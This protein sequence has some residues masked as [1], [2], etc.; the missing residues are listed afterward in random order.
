MEVLTNWP[1]YLNINLHGKQGLKAKKS[2]TYGILFTVGK[3]I[4]WD[5]C[6]HVFYPSSKGLSRVNGDCYIREMI[7]FLLQT[8]INLVSLTVFTGMHQSGQIILKDWSYLFLQKCVCD[9]NTRSF[10]AFSFPPCGAH[11]HAPAPRSQP[12]CQ[13]ASDAGGPKACGAEAGDPPRDPNQY[14]DSF[15]RQRLRWLS[16]L[17]A[18]FAS[19]CFQSYCLCSFKHWHLRGSSLRAMTSTECLKRN[20]PSGSEDCEGKESCVT[21]QDLVRKSRRTFDQH[22]HHPSLEA[23]A[24]HHREPQRNLRLCFWYIQCSTAVTA[25]LLLFVITVVY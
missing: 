8:Q 10:K 24:G 4:N 7:C 5:C 11:S 25:V 22:F 18:S 2:W 15:R 17:A 9:G 1:A 21:G 16:H 19:V 6:W 13:N 3:K 12:S 14:L 23:S 20:S